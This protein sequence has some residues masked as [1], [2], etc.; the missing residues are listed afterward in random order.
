[1]TKT[2]G[3]ADK[4]NRIEALQRFNAVPG[5]SLTTQNPEGFPTFAPEKVEV[6]GGWPSFSDAGRVV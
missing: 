5:L 4:A 6:A 2:G 1:M 3:L